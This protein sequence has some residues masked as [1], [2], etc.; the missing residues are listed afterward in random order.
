M[1]CR[2]PIGD[3]NAIGDL[4]QKPGSWCEDDARDVGRE[5]PLDDTPFWDNVAFRL[6]PEFGWLGVKNTAY[7]GCP[8]DDSVR[9]ALSPTGGARLKVGAMLNEALHGPGVLWGT[10]IRT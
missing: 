9:K 8:A 7:D 1:D 6:V 4:R 10:S 2:L 3:L 5:A